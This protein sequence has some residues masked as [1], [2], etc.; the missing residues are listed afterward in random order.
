M[1][2]YCRVQDIEGTPRILKIVIG[3]GEYLW[4]VISEMK[5]FIGYCR[6]S[7][8]KQGADGYGMTAQR[9]AV[10]RFVSSQSGNLLA[11]FA[12]VESGKVNDRPELAKALALVKKHRATLVI[13]KLDRLSRSASFLLALQ[14]A[15][16][17]FVAC[18]APNVDR[19]T[20]GILALVAQRER[21]LIS[22]R[23]KSGMRIA[24]ERG[25]KI[26]SPNP[27][28]SVKAMN[29]G[30]TQARVAF[31]SKMLPVVSQIRSCGVQTL[32]GVADALNRLGHATRQGKPW[33]PSHVWNLLQTQTA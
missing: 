5:T 14:D 17:D 2:I 28:A 4:Q 25:A 6:V 10:S 3:T 21:E 11:E 27:E 19:F 24:K 31:A 20:C 8:E 9:E 18:D 12:E 16:V 32:Q 22:E 26:G 15:G 30:A 29:A 13:A 23:T 33:T 7:T 1:T